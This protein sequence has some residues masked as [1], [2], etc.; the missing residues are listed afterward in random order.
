MAEKKQAIF[1]NDDSWRFPVLYPEELRARIRARADF[2]DEIYSS[3]DLDDPALAGLFART[4]VIFS[5]WGMPAL[6]EKQIEAHFPNLEA[7]YYAAGTVQYFARPFLKRGVRVFSAWAANGVPVV[8]F[9]VAQIVLA[10]K[11][12]FQSLRRYRERDR[13]AAFAYTMS[14]PCNYNIRVGILGAGVIGREV[15]ARLKA[16]HYEVLAYDPYVSDEVLSSLGAKRASLEEIFSTCQII[17]NHVA[18]LPATVGMIDG[19]LLHSM[20][21][22]AAFI[23]TGRGAQVV[24]SELIAALKACPDRTAL[25]DVTWPEPPE[26]GSEFYTLPNVFLTPHIAGSQNNEWARMALYMVEEFERTEDH[27]PV[28]YEVTEKMLE[29]MA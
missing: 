27:L 9:T 7:V 5:S 19:K 11:G 2:S 28:R 3:K 4:R 16:Y 12:Y 20:L 22:N 21:P 1:F 10:G 25:L 24:E 17:S 15:M 23:N 14:L 29:T 6:T 13:K 26:E 8:E 18:N